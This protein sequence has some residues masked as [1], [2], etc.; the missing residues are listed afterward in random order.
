[1]V[2]NPDYLGKFYAPRA[3]KVVRKRKLAHYL[4][5]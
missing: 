4:G 5:P 2:E 3:P 1:M